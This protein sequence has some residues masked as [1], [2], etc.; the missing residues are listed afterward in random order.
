VD[1]EDEPPLPDA[2][3]DDGWDV[4]AI[5]GG[6]TPAVLEVEEVAAEVVVEVVAPSEPVKQLTPEQAAV[7]DARYGEAVVR[8][9]LD[10]KFISEEVTAPTTV[11]TPED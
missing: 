4:V 8:E 7:E 6:G 11:I 3:S 10:A 2:P 5:P 1:L 9:L